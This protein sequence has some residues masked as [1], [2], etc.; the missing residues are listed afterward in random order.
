MAI[1]STTNKAH[2]TNQAGSVP[3]GGLRFDNLMAVLSLALAGGLYL[4]GWAHNHGRVD[5]TF[6]T[7]WHGV[8][9]GMLFLNAIV[10]GTVLVINHNRGR[11]WISALPRGYVASFLGSPLF[12]VAG[13]GDLIW[14][15]LFGFEVGIEPLLS[16][17]HLLL[18]LSGFLIM[19]GPVRSVWHRAESSKEQGWMLLLSPVLALTSIFSL[20]TFFTTY[21]HPLNIART[22]TIQPYNRDYAAW[23]VTGIILESVVYMGVILFALRRWRLPLGS[24]TL[25]FTLN[26]ALMSVFR[27]Q[28]IL[29]LP[30]FLAGIITDLVYARL[31]PSAQHLD[32]MRIFSFFVP[33]AY[34]LLLLL[35]IILLHGTAWSIHLW[36]GTTF[37]AGV[38]GLLLGCLVFPAPLPAPAEKNQK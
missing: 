30:I 20:F 29:I 36:L 16:P 10:L 5:N 18:A 23:G 27:D 1:T 13:I 15:Q 3:I 25:I 34:T 8:L 31:R 14:H 33:F 21:A 11:S 37:I 19:S 7:P 4:D 35:T 9:Y 6:F 24:F 22:I 2:T 38:V 28:Y 26:A 32:A 17:T 12:F